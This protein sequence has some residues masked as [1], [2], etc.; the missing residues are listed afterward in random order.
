VDTRSMGAGPAQVLRDVMLQE[1]Q[2]A[3]EEQQQPK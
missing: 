2:K 1:R 3:I